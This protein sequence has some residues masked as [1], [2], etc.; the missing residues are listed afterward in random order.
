MTLNFNNHLPSAAYIMYTGINLGLKRWRQ[1]RR[2][3]FLVF[4]VE[5]GSAIKP[6]PEAVEI[7]LC[8]F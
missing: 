3:L 2:H 6:K 4:C 8:R 5:D 7:Y 1:R